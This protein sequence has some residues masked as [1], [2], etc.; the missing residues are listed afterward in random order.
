MNPK[1]ID[2]V[3]VGTLKLI[4]VLVVGAVVLKIFGVI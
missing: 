2:A 1:T 4:A 3:F